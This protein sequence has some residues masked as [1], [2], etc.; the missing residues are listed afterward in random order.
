M[1][2]QSYI[3]TQLANNATTFTAL[4][5]SAT[6][7]EYYFKPDENSWCMLEVLCH[8]IDEEV[9]DFRT[10]VGVL[11][12]N[13]SEPLPKINPV[14]WVKERNYIGRDF[15]TM[16]QKFITERNNSVIWLIELN[17]PNWQSTHFHPKLGPVTASYFLENWLAHDYLHIRQITRLRY[18]Y[19]QKV[20]Q[21]ALQYAGNW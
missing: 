1:T 12:E 3:I 15:T 21:N 9:E 16:V 7:E 13:P 11:L 17:S 6:D 2:I 18:Q 19:L 14:G 4:L 10:R 20:S 5:N 8:L